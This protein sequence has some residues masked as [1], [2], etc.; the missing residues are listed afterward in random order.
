MV[1]ST[2]SGHLLIIDIETVSASPDFESLSP[3][4]QRCWIEKTAWSIPE[5]ET[6]S[7]FYHQRAGVMAEF[8]KVI[9]ISVGIISKSEKME[10]FQ[11]RSFAGED[12]PELLRCFINE[13]ESL[14]TAHI[15]YRF[16]GHNIREFDIPFLC[17]RMIINGLTVPASMD[18]QGRKPW[19]TDMLDTFQYW[20]FGDYKQYTSL[21][22]LAMALGIPSPKEDID[23]SRVGEVF[24]KENGLDRIVAYCKRDVITVANIIRRFNQQPLLTEEQVSFIT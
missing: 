3:D 1:S 21:K 7:G 11:V 22:L 2:Q 4:W 15:R 24:W 16:A 23:G 13:L 19:E 20:R 10:R 8:A 6:P 12:E 18:L 9:C 17:R 14:Q 5:G